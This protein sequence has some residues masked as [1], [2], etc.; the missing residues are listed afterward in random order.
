MN[1]SS[2][3]QNSK[4]VPCLFEFDINASQI[5]LK[6]AFVKSTFSIHLVFA[7][8]DGVRNNFESFY[9]QWLLLLF[10]YL[11]YPL[12]RYLVY[13]SVYLMTPDQDLA[14]LL[15]LPGHQRGHREA[16]RGV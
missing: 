4:D 11:H 2:P 16:L 15:H 10:P 3:T 14:L 9:P 5:C 7:L 1:Y 8:L 6:A 13:I 12:Y